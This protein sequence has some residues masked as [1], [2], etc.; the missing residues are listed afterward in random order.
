M[1][2][3]LINNNKAFFVLCVFAAAILLAD[4]AYFAYSLYTLISMLTYAVNYNTA[5]TSVS[6]A[7]IVLNSFLIAVFGAYLL[8]RK[9]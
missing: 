5:F 8:L 3:K 1:L 2:K 7:A 9:K 4:V 6:I